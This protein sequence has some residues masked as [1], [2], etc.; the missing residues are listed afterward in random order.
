METIRYRAA[1][2]HFIDG[3]K[4]GE[5]HAKTLDDKHVIIEVGPAQ[6]ISLHRGLDRS[7]EN[8]EVKEHKVEG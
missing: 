4:S 2:A 8:Y 5:V 7:I 6:Q 1:V 3:A